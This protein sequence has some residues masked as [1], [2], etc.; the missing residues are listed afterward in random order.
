MS[1]ISGL[2]AI[3]NREFKIF[4]REKS[5]I[6]AM[7]INPLMWIFIF[8]GGLGSSFSVENLNYQTFIYP[9]VIVMTI[10]FTSTF[11]GAYIIWDKRLDFL[12]EVLVA[13]ISRTTIFMGK[14]LG[15]VT[16]AL[17]QASLLLL[18]APLFGI[19]FG[20]NFFLVYIFLFVMTISLVGIGLTIG[21]MMESPEGFS[22]IGS[23]I[24][25]PLFFLSGAL[26]PLENLPA[27]L[28][29]MTR[30][31]PLTYGVDAMRGLIL[32]T[33]TFGLLTDFIV[34]TGFAAA[35][36][37]IGTFAFRRMKL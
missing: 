6:V 16:D 21:S 32:G 8:G 22:L 14:V 33:T 17:I 34:M 35:M 30:L 12:K 9:G 26:Y 20:L 23:F 5:R 4:L 36:V 15:G 1:E 13:P 7:I 25:F 2:Y 10:L 3:W 11:Y 29:M 27:W 31:N 28:M 18:L 24:N 19:P 37:V